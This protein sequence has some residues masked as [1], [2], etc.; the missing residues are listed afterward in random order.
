MAILTMS[1]FQ[2][3]DLITDDLLG[4]S[5]LISLIF[6]LSKF[7]NGGEQKLDCLE[8]QRVIGNSR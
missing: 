1:L 4:N 8:N 3:F 2:E 6:I 7:E 5:L